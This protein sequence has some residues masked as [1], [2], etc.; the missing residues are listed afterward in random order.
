MNDVASFSCIIDTTDS[1]CP[2]GIEIWLDGLQIFN[3]S[4]V[5]NSII[6]DHVLSDK[7]SEHTLQFVMKGKTLEHTVVDSAGNIMH[8]ARLLINDLKFDHI[9]LGHTLTELADYTHDYNGTGPTTH[10]K[11]YGEIGCNGTIEL[12]FTTPLYLWL[13]E[14]L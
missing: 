11:F 4:H 1:A 14:H 12:K 13:L 10:S 9:A 5:T 3:D 7:D 8:D 6:F 2:L